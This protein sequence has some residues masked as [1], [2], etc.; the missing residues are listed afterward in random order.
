MNNSYSYHDLCNEL[1][2]MKLPNP[3]LSYEVIG[4]SVMGKEIMALRLGQG[5]RKI[6]YNAAIHANEWIT[7]VLLIK[8]INDC[9]RCLEEEDYIWQGV[10]IHQLLQEITIWFVPLLNPD[11]VELVLDGIG[12]EHEFKQQL[13]AWNNNSVD[14]TGWKA[15]IHGVDLNDQFPAYWEEE[16][17]R[18]QQSK[19]G[20]M[21]YSGI[22][23]LSEPEAR[24]IANFTLKH[25]FDLVL[26]LHTQGEEIYW[27]Y[28]GFEPE[29]AEGLADKLASVS[30]YCAVY[31]TDSD[32]GYKDWF[33]QQFR[34]PGFTIEAGYGI[35]PLPIEQLDQIYEKVSKILLLGL[36]C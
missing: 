14:F 18:R 30:G 1:Q 35:N 21:N 11:G 26:S 22:A 5:K 9:V 13:L 27:N 33:I 17:V 4:Y 20:P 7:A 6:H 32:A 12:A 24:A 25:A 3:Y 34:R 2:L 28:R 8:F 10:H 23:P 16:R 36:T 19:P 15:N 29:K 31:L